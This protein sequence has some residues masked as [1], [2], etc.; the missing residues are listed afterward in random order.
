MDIRD[1]EHNNV[2]LKNCQEK[3][4]ICMK[5]CACLLTRFSLSKANRL[6][7]FCIGQP[8]WQAVSAKS[9]KRKLKGAD[10]NNNGVYL[11][12]PICLSKTLRT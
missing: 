11:P 6:I 5:L 12:V 1:L 3:Q 2:N 9:V 10:E 8:F 4:D 7:L